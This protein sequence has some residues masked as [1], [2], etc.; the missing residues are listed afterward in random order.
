MKATNID[1]SLKPIPNCYII[2]PNAGVIMP[3][4]PA[5]KIVL[6]ILPEI[7]DSKMATYQ[8]A[9]VIGRSFPIKTYSH[10]DNRTISMKAHFI[11]LA[12]SDVTINMKILRALQSAV[13]PQDSN[14]Q[15]YLPPPICKIRVGD[16]LSKQ[17][18]CVVLRQYNWS[19]PTDVAW[20]SDPQGQ[21]PLSTGTYLPYKF[22]MDLTWDVVY[23]N[24]KLP[25]QNLILGDM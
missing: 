22:D 23:P 1:G 12:L 13:Y 16:L 7:T 9:T 3:P 14:S 17:D 19:A 18:L 6:R 10:G 20:F 4:E 21:S 5:G 25:G 2:V 24:D 11:I 15:P 8:D